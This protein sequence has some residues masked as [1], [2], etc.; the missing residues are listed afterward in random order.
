MAE[1]SSQM[2]K[3]YRELLQKS[4][5][6]YSP[7]TTPTYQ[8]ISLQRKVLGLEKSEGMA[9]AKRLKEQWYTERSPGEEPKDEQRSQ[10]HHRLPTR[11]HE[12]LRPSPYQRRP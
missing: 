11:R 2:L 3:K 10:G 5:T 4:P 7:G 12:R 6:A 9:E 8:D 1:D